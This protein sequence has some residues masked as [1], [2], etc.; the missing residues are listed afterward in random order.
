MRPPTFQIS[1]L[2]SYSHLHWFFFPNDGRRAARL[3]W[4][5]IAAAASTSSC[6]STADQLYRSYLLAL[7]GLLH[8]RAGV[9]VMAWPAPRPDLGEALVAPNSGASL[10]YDGPF[11]H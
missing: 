3:P 4:T 2:Y 6:S 7:P 9:A 10:T 8:S 5:T 11:N 1:L